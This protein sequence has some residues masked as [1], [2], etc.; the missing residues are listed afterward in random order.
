MSP[1]SGRQFHAIAPLLQAERELV[2]VDR[3]GFGHSDP[4]L[5]PLAFREY[6]RAT[7]DG[8]DQLGI[9]H[10][11]LLGIHTGTSEAI[12]LAMAAPQRVRGLVLAALPVF[13]DEELRDFRA[14]YATA[15]SIADDGSHPAATWQR[16]GRWQ[17]EAEGWTSELTNERVLEDVRAWPSSAPMYAALFDYAIGE[18][19]PTIT[20]PLLVFAPRDD[21][22]TQTQRGLELLPDH[23][24]VIDLSHLSH[25]IFAL[26]PEE[27]AD[28][29]RPF[30]SELDA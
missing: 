17:D 11:D 16:Y 27:L 22:L 18:L 8:L 2:L 6:A 10:F 23:A 20:H 24:H 9:E 30:L 4:I 25:E 1:Q 19:L 12:A 28:H 7:L 14:I 26:H 29:L 13:S 15:P 5:G 21:I 3:L